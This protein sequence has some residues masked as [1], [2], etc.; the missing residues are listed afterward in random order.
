MTE[1]FKHWVI[2]LTAAG[3]ISILIWGICK[4]PILHINLSLLES[5]GLVMIAVAVSSG[6]DAY[7]TIETD[8]ND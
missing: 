1:A 4:I 7:N 3:F 8:E 6:Q 5:W 2:G